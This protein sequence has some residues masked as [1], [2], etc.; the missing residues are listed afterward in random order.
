MKKGFFIVFIYLFFSSFFI[1]SNILADEDV[2]RLTVDDVVRMAL[3]NNLS[4]KVEQFKEKAAE[5]DVKTEEGE[6]DPLLKFDLEKSVLNQ[7]VPLIFLSSEETSSGFDASL[8]GKI[9]T[10]TSYSL[11]WVNLKEEGNSP[12]LTLNP[13]YSS[14][15][16]I[17]ISQPILKGFGT[18]TQSAMIDV[19]KNKHEISKL[20]LGRET[21]DV[22]ANA[23]N[24]YWNMLVVKNLLEVDRLSLEL[25]ERLH[26]EIK[27]RIKVG[28]MA[29]VDIY[30]AE[31]EIAKREE[32]IISVEKR[33]EDAEDRLKS[34][35]NMSDW[36]VKIS[37]V[38]VPPDSV[39]IP[40]INEVVEKASSQRRVYK[41]KSLEGK[42]KAILAKYYKNQRLPDLNVYGSYGLNSVDENYSKAWES[43][44]LDEHYSWQL[45]ANLTVPIGN[46]LAK[47][48][49]Y[50]A[51]YEEEQVETELIELKKEIIIESR[52]AWRAV[53][54]ADKR[55]VATKKTRIAAKKRLEA[56][57][58]RF[59]VG[60]G[61]LND[62]LKFQEEYARA[63]FRER[64]ATIDYAK[65]IVNLKR[66]QGELPYGL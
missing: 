25:A 61:T 8:E 19:S 39:T 40:D 38:S 56:E 50:R 1:N 26:D 21:I 5:A 12:F 18:S 10:G 6:F 36:N 63:I 53:K 66:V 3:E 23:V 13:Y 37:A 15:L 31:A 47:G 54:L 30:Q 17:E 59:K 2:I 48:N 29:P 52:K 9:K 4:I 57:E 41:E 51:K 46:R 43:P 45:G 22:V 27:A 60:L 42:N 14:D 11:S 32:A 49:Y 44:D 58:G 34:I 33:I 64:K 35:L 7:E 16:M 20:E 28:I 24:A 62:L 65:S 55:I